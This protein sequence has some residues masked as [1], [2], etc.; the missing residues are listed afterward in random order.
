M[1]QAGRAGFIH[2]AV[3]QPAFNPFAEYCRALPQSGRTLLVL[4]LIGVELPAAS[5]AI[6]VV[7]KNGSFR[8][9]VPARHYRAGVAALQANLPAGKYIVQITVEG[10]QGPHRVAFPLS[11]GAWWGPLIV[12]AFAAL[13]IIV[14]AASYCLYQV[15]EGEAALRQVAIKTSAGCPRRRA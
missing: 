9:S 3:Y 7:K 10:P 8:L 15:R 12:P 6:D 4:D 13:L 14:A 1:G 11:V 5:I 2:L